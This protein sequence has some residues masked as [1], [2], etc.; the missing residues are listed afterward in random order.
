MRLK[1]E[2]RKEDGS[3]MMRIRDRTFIDSNVLI[4][5]VDRRDC[6]ML[7]KISFWDALIVVSARSS[8]C[9]VLASEDLSD[10][11]LINGV[12][13]FNPFKTQ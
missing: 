4:Y 1:E 2:V 3:A 8:G 12:R 10:A 6:S 11:Q 9:R 13:V 5:A 7:S